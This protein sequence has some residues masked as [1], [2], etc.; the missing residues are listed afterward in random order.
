MTRFIVVPQWQGSASSRAMQLI[1]GAEAIAGDLP[2][3]ATVRLPVPL[4][5]GD[6]LG[7]TVQRL[8]ALQRVRR[9]L[10]VAVRATKDTV[11]VVGGDCSVAVGAVAAVAEADVA[12]VWLDA[13]PDA[14]T[15]ETSPSGAFCGMA[16]RSILGEGPE[17]LT[18]P[19]GAVS[20]T[21]VILAGT[22][23]LDLEEE[24][25]VAGEGIRM[26]PAATLS[27]HDAL[28]EAVA[29]TGAARVY[30]HVDLDVLDPAE[31]SGIGSADPFGVST[32]DLV[33]SLRSLHA[34][35]P[36]VGASITGFAPSSPA[37]AVDDLGTI[38]RIIGALA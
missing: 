30:V 27:E 19:T 15:P 36:L 24:L 6:P 13:H 16:L 31:I 8:S 25:F 11:I 22:R 28:A 10:E 21:R 12:L 17:L 14:H 34:R 4:E 23:S 35:V 32:A 29:A 18:L 33:A 37:A 9:D 7:T 2:T 1:D 20:P 26:L 3:S 5:A 38:L